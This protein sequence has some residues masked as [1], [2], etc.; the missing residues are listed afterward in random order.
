MAVW[1]GHVTR[2]R[3]VPWC[4]DV[5]RADAMDGVRARNGRSE[6]AVGLGAAGRSDGESRVDFAGTNG[7]AEKLLGSQTV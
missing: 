5:L 7:A 1:R 3:I 2:A 4:P 6:G